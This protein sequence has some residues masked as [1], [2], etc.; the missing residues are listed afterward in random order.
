MLQK[1]FFLFYVKF[2][3][4]FDTKQSPKGV[5]SPFFYRDILHK[6]EKQI[7]L[8]QGR[9][10]TLKIMQF[11]Q[12]ANN[13]FWKKFWHT[14]RWALILKIFSFMIFPLKAAWAGQAKWSAQVALRGK[15]WKK[16]IFKNL[17]G[18][19]NVSIYNVSCDYDV[20][21]PSLVQYM[22]M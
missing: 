17:A 13:I 22:Y 20:W 10:W 12:Y 7:V 3:I 14:F 16:T 5:F 2:L 18:T 11:Q 1:L 6:T 9:W 21:R 4:Y 15:S 8:L 19:I